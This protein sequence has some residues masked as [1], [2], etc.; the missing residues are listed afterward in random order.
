MNRG[1]LW[2]IS[3]TT[4]PEHV[5]AERG[6]KRLRLRIV[7]ASELCDLI[8]DAP[9]AADSG[10]GTPAI[11]YPVGAVDVTYTY[12]PFIPLWDFP[13]LR[14]HATLPPER[15]ESGAAGKR[16]SDSPY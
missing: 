8:G 9:P 15:T 12:L 2:K 4:T 1:A 6:R 10:E 7:R 13:A 11:T 3:V 16:V 5:S 14:I